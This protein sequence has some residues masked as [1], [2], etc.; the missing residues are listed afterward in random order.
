MIIYMDILL[1]IVLFILFFYLL[2]IYFYIFHLIITL[3]SKKHLL[4]TYVSEDFASEM[5]LII[6]EVSK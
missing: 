4:K 1:L 5:N 6:Y 2:C 3:D